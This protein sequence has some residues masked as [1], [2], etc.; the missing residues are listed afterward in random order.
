VGGNCLIPL[1]SELRQASAIGQA[2]FAIIEEITASLVAISDKAVRRIEIGRCNFACA[3][4]ADTATA[5]QEITEGK[6]YARPE[7]S[8]FILWVDLKI[9]AVDGKRRA[10]AFIFRGRAYR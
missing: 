1:L 9:K 10:W 5:S 3:A 4:Y 7:T 6:S 2:T 8:R